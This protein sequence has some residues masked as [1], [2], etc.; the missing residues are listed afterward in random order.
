MRIISSNQEEGYVKLRPETT[1]DLWYLSRVIA[2]KDRIEAYSQRRYRPPGAKADSGEKKTVKLLVE[3]TGVEFAEASNKLRVTGPIISGTP[4]EYVQAGDYHTIDV[5]PHHDIKLYKKVDY[6]AKAVLNEAVKRSRH[7][8][9]VVVVMDEHKAVATIVQTRGSKQ[10]FEIE[11]AASKRRADDFDAKQAK[12]FAEVLDALKA[13]QCDALIIAGPGFQKDNFK[14]YM[15]ERAPELLRKTVFEHASSAEKSA[16]SE[17]LKKGVVVRALGSLKLLEETELLERFK[18][19]LGKNDGLSTYGEKEVE[20]AVNRGAAE[21][22][23]VLDEHLRASPQAR[24]LMER[25]ES[26]GAQVLVFDANDDAGAEFAA[27]KIAALLR[28]KK[29]S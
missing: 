4:E 29:Y 25:A 13:T 22:I 26:G 24:K 23:M 17:L 8:K 16:L 12:F 20:D 6:A 1:E 9:G 2:P 7:V 15:T 14:E 3:V 28:Y 27:F 19:S 10:L 21:T 18:Q 5:E 11:N